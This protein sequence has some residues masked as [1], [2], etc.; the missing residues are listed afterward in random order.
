[1]PHINLIHEQR[2][3]IRRKEAQ[4]RAGLMLFVTAVGLTAVGSGGLLLQSQAVRWEQDRLQAELA[5]LAPI[6]KQI[7][8]NAV[9]KDRLAPRLKT[10]EDARRATDR[11]RRI[12]DHVSTNT[13]KEAWLLTLRAVADNPVQPVSVTFNGMAMAQA[14]IGELL[15]RTQNCPDLKDVHLVYTEERVNNRTKG[16]QFEFV[17]NV[18]GEEPEKKTEGTK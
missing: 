11:W 5:R 18:A 7:D 8:D 9:E 3:S 4:A 15:L 16:I 14:P 6:A 13:P 12:L 10:L 17:A 1:M 2:S